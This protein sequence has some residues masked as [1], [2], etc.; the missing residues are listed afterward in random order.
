MALHLLHADLLIV[1]VGKTFAGLDCPRQEEV[2]TISFI[3]VETWC[4]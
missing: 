2:H 4:S 3:E 1:K